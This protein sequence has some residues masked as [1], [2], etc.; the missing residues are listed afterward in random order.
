MPPC[1]LISCLV[2]FPILCQHAYK[3]NLLAGNVHFGLQFW[4]PQSVPNWLCCFGVYGTKQY[5]WC[6]AKQSCSPRW[7]GNRIQG[8]CWSGSLYPLQSP[9]FKVL[10]QAHPLKSSTA[11]QNHPWLRTSLKHKD[12]RWAL[13][14][15]TVT[16]KIMDMVC[17]THIICYKT[18]F[19]H[20]GIIK[21]RVHWKSG[22]W[23]ELWRKNG[24]HS[25]GRDGQLWW[26]W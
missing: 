19:S 13:K 5:L 10:K 26:W 4:G 17:I 7:L 2:T 14:I 18:A 1:E 16:E 20:L 21:K 23:V 6:I 11:P 24:I 15:Q 8:T 3:S 9:I 22:T 12:L 25:R